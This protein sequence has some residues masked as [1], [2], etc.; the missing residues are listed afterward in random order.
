[1]RSNY[2]KLNK[3]LAFSNGNALK[4]VIDLDRDKVEKDLIL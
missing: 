3:D 2:K 4:V 1:M